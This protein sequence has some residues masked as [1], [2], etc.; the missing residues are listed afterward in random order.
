MNEENKENIEKENEQIKTEIEDV[1]NEKKDS[2]KPEETQSEESDS[3]KPEE[4]QSEKGDSEKL[5]ETQSEE[6]DSEEIEKAVNKDEMSMT[7][8][9]SLIDKEPEK[10]GGMKFS[11]YFIS[12]LVDTALSLGISAALMF[13][14]DKI[15]RAAAGLY[16]IQSQIFT[17][18]LMI[19]IGVSVFY[20]SI[21]KTVSG[22][23]PGQKLLKL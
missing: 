9:L 1:Q 11:K 21:S 20:Y 22:T 23:T 5:E 17:V 4:T 14:I 6:S 16:F 8:D 7:D 19:F 18:L 15:L 13:I 3:E 2:E 10:K 12:S